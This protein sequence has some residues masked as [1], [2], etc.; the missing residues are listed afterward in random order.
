MFMPIQCIQDLD[1][2]PK[3]DLYQQPN[4]ISRKKLQ[5]DQILFVA[6]YAASK[7]KLMGKSILPK[8]AG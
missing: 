2:Q 3:Q 5:S 4:Y 8:A 6:I 1:V 7:H